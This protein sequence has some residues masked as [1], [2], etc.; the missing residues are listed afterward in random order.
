MVWTWKDKHI[1]KL[2]YIFVKHAVLLFCYFYYVT[3]EESWPDA[4]R[5]TQYLQAVSLQA[6]PECGESDEAAGSF[7]IL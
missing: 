4:K 5:E 7:A 6:T 3:R 1:P 2:S